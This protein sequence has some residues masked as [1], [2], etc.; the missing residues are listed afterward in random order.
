MMFFCLMFALY[1]IHHEP[2]STRNYVM[3]HE[4]TKEPEMKFIFL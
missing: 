2:S 4:D 3:Y 1:T